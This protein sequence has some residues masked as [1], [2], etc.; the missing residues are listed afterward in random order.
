MKK[1]FILITCIILTVVLTVV[2]IFSAGSAGYKSVKN[3]T[4]R[5]D[6][7]PGIGA[8]FLE[9]DKPAGFDATVCNDIITWDELKNPPPE[10]DAENNS[11][12][13]LNPYTLWLLENY[14]KENNLGIIPENYP[15]FHLSA[16]FDECLETFHFVEL[17]DE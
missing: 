8:F 11:W 1:K 16:D 9:L 12:F 10:F 17:T 15:D 14:M 3:A 6:K 2:L 4:I 7:I 13:Y 5:L